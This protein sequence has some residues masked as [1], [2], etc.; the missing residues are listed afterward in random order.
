MDMSAKRELN[1][2]R[3]EIMSLAKKK[4]ITN[5]YSAKMVFG[6]QNKII[7]MLKK[8]DSLEKDLQVLEGAD[9]YKGGG[10]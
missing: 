7:N 6:N 5:Q 1:R 3:A 4:G 10:R 8:V 9:R 2:L